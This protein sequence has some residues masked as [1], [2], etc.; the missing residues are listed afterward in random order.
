MKSETLKKFRETLIN[1]REKLVHDI[2]HLKN[3]N[4]KQSQKDFS[5]DLSG[6]SLHLADMGS[7]DFERTTALGLVSQEQD[8]IYYIDEA[9]RKIDEGTFGIC[10]DCKKTIGLKRLEAVPYAQLCISCKSHEER[11]K[12]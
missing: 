1:A 11:K 4:L 12:K 10:E 7:D 5:G 9:L 8:I 3:D 2:D 6:Y